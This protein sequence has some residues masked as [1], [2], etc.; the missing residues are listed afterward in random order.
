MNFS[1]GISLCLVALMA[2]C[3]VF[4]SSLPA[5]ACS[6]PVFK[7]ALAYWPADP[8][9]MIIFHSGSMSPDKQILLDK[10]KKMSW[11]SEASSNIIVRTVDLAASPGVVMQKLWESQ[12]S[13]ELPWMI[14]RYPRVSGITE[15]IWAGELT[16]D[17]MDAVLDSPVRQEI[18][19]RILK[20]ETAV[21][22]FL[23]SGDQKQDDEAASIIESQLKVLS[24]EMRVI[25]EEASIEEFDE[26]DLQVSF[27]MLRLSRND[28]AER[29]LIQM[30]LNS[31]WDLKMMSK[32]MAFPIFGRGRAL[33]ALIGDGIRARNIEIAC[34][35]LVGW[36]S[37][38]IKDQ[39]PGL[40]ILMS[41]SWDKAI[42][43][44][45]YVQTTQLLSSSRETATEES[46]N[47]DAIK[48]NI[49]IVFVLIFLVVLALG[50]FIISRRKKG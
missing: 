47:G 49:I 20:G 5:Q 45:L 46:G 37:C 13:E 6:V 19:Q 4:L 26:D 3:I 22:L 39:N 14:L 17:N 15:Q 38:E 48:R 8:Y 32:P 34:S 23:E 11:D 41:V 27:S 31:E 2:A 30:L 24:E 50:F 9:E 12:S 25:V 18:A 36:C 29:M 43:E 1:S 35:F 33:Y 44:N 42:D 7:Y 28:P 16:A 10:L 21:W 40:D